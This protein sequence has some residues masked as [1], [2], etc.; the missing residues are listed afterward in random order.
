MTRRGTS[1]SEA[2]I[3]TASARGEKHAHTKAQAERT[4]AS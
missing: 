1:G 4:T 3:P 2:V